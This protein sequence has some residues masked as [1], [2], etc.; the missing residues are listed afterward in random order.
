M[1]IQR[2]HAT[3]NTDEYQMNHNIKDRMAN[4]I[5]W[6]AGHTRWPLNHIEEAALRQGPMMH[7]DYRFMDSNRWIRACCLWSLAYIVKVFT[8]KARLSL[9]GE[10]HE[11]PLHGFLEPAEY[12]HS[13]MNT[14][15]AMH[16]LQCGSDESKCERRRRAIVSI[17]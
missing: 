15:Y 16:G 9:E 5:W 7:V 6:A 4:T 11:L 8:T 1:N 2:R 17:D 10:I 12:R 14:A 3:P 13:R